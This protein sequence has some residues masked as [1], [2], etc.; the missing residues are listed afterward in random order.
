MATFRFVGRDINIHWNGYDIKGPAGTVFSIPDQLY[1]EFEGDLRGAEPS[2]EW[3]DTNE[4]L[5]LTN[6]VSVTTLDG[7]FPISSTT[8]S[9]GKNISIVSTS[10]SDGFV[11]TANGSG[12]VAWEALPGDATGITSIIGTSPISAAVSGTQATITIDQ[13]AITGA[14]SATNAQVVRFLVKNTTGTTIPKG[15]AVYVSGATGDNA[16][17]SLASATSETTSSKTLGITA[18]AIATDAFGY[19]I[20]AGYLTDIDTSATTAGAAVWLG[21]TPG[22]LVFVSPPAEPSHAVYLGVVVRVQSNNGSILVKVQNGYELDELHDVFVTGVSTSLPLVYSS[23]SSGWI[24]QA[25]SSVGIADNAIVA[26]K[27]AAAA[28]GSAAIATGS[29][30]STHIGANAVVAGDIAASA[31]TSGNLATGAVVSAAIAASAVTSG[32]IAASAVGT[33]ALATGAV[34]A[35]KIATGAVTSGHIASGAVGSAALADNAV[36]AAKIAA[37]AVGTAALSS[38]SAA[39]GTVLTANGSGAATFQAASASGSYWIIATSPLSAS[40]ITSAPA[41]DYSLRNA[42]RDT[43]TIN[44]S[45]ATSSLVNGKEIRVSPL[46]SITTVTTADVSGWSNIIDI[47]FG[48]SQVFDIHYGNSLFVAVGNDGKLSTSI[49][50]TSW[51]SRTSGFG[52]SSNSIRGVAY[53]NSLWVAVGQGGK[54][55]TSID[56]VSWTS[57]TS[58]HGSTTINDVVYGGSLWITIGGNNKVYSSPD[59]ITWTGRSAGFSSTDSQLGNVEYLNS[60]TYII[61]GSQS[62]ISPR[63]STSANGTSWST[64][65]TLLSGDAAV[66]SSFGSSLYVVN[67]NTGS[68]STAPST[69]LATWTARGVAAGSTGG[70]IDFSGSRFRK[71]VGTR[72]GL[73]TDGI[74]WTQS[75]PVASD[76]TNVTSMERVLYDGSKYVALAASNSSISYGVTTS[77]TGI[78]VSGQ[79]NVLL[80]PI[81]TQT[82]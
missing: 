8:T 2:L 4:F 22:S 11:L 19:V 29:I 6:A 36:V 72:F 50:G 55:F 66:G 58:G 24:A 42:S 5:T 45:S 63:V 48:T 16:L 74:N 69:D 21:N 9:S 80:S 65:T 17:I 41:G 39:N 27:I 1:E 25:L 46:S 53:G 37:A 32:H 71:D 54:C 57:R 30:N 18:E 49:N 60:S 62:G 52:T 34:V 23:T 10:A 7:I 79:I 43:I 76:L 47:N 81:T 35:A 59:G 3:I 38:G 28:V 20:E 68:I 64:R 51:T 77:A 15:S 67:S 82:I 75:T 33:A 78:D 61:C 73:S 13:S 31:V 12:G 26:A 44:A 40:S 70:R 56:A 14:I